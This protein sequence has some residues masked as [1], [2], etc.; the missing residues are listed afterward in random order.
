MMSNNCKTFLCTQKHIRTFKHIFLISDI[1][2]KANVHINVGIGSNRIIKR[3]LLQKG[4]L[5]MIISKIII[6]NYVC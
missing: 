3:W 5:M 1:S 6:H 2:G 4:F